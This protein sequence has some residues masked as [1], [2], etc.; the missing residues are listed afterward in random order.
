M[1]ARYNEIDVE[2]LQVCLD[3]FLPF[4]QYQNRLRVDAEVF[5]QMYKF[6]HLIFC[7]SLV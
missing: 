2:R 7:M 5:G 3:S 6:I 4:I 1:R